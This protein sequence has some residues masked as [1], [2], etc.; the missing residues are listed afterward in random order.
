MQ[1]TVTTDYAIRVLLYLTREDKIINSREL[2]EQVAV[3]QNYLQKLIR[4]L[5]QRGIVQQYRGVNGGYALARRPSQITLYD[6]IYTME[7]RPYVSGCSRDPKSCNVLGPQAHC[8][9]HQV[10]LGLQKNDDLYLKSIN[11]HDLVHNRAKVE[12]IVANLNFTR[13]IKAED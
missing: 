2:S 12:D 8:I 3:S 7:T 6:V 10:F 9:V 5:V 11:F 1:I 4:K 13:S